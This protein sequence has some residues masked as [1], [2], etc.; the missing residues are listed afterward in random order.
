MS[1]THPNPTGTPASAAVIAPMHATGLRRG[2]VAAAVD[3]NYHRL[4]SAALGLTIALLCFSR[5]VSKNLLGVAVSLL[6]VPLVLGYYRRFSRLRLSMGLMCLALYSVASFFWSAAPGIT[7]RRLPSYLAPILVAFTTVPV[8][9]ITRT[10]RMVERVLRATMVFNITMSVLS[11]SWMEDPI[12]QIEGWV[13]SFFSKNYFGLSM[14][15]G[16]ATTALDRKVKLR[17]LWLAGFTYL[18]IKCGSATA[19]SLLLASL[20][21]FAAVWA[22]KRVK[23]RPTR[24]FAETTLGMVAVTAIAGAVL[25][26]GFVTSLLG[27]DATFTGRTGIWTYIWRFIRMKPYT[28]H[29]YLSMFYV[30]NNFSNNLQ[31]EVGF[32]VTSAHQGYLDFALNFGLI[33]LAALVGALLLSISRTFDQ[34]L[35]RD[36]RLWTRVLLLIFLVEGFSE[37]CFTNPFVVFMLLPMAGLVAAGAKRHG[38]LGPLAADAL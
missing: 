5:V 14:V 35:P 23:S 12:F 21:F 19:L 36:D 37:S 11:P 29:G 7:M 2:T 13:G 30:D 18:V 6:C 26:L 1:I 25:N 32:A 27:R 15:I 24:V 4:A 28:G 16:F 3:R 31:R 33:G 38:A 22:S 34:R 20:A 8:L 17:P 9:G 10:R